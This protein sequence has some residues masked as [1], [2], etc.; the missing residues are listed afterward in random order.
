MRNLIFFVVLTVSITS[1]GQKN[2]KP[3][4]PLPLFTVNNK[5]VSANEFIYLYSQKN[6]GKPEDFTEIK[7]NEYL[8]LFINFK[9]KVAEAQ[10][11]GMDT[12]ASFRK[13]FD[14]YKDELKKPYVAESNELNRLTKETYANLTEEIKASHILITLT[15]NPTPADTIAALQKLT[16]IRTKA[17]GGEDFGKLAQEFSEDPSAKTNNGNLGYFTAMQ[18]VYPFEAAAYKTKVGEISFPVRTRFGYHIIKVFDR[19]PARGEVEVSHILLR[20]GSDN[21]TKV[22]NTI[23]EIYDQLKGGRNWE[24]LCTEYSE[25][26]ATKTNGGKLR[27][28]GVGALASVPEFEKVAFNLQ[29]PGDISDPFQ[30]AIGWHL[31]RLE[32][33]IPVPSYKEIEPSLKRRVSRDE[34]LQI[35]KTALLA[36]RKRELNFAVGEALQKIQS[37]ADTSLIRGRWKY[38]G[39]EAVKNQTLFTIQSNP[40]LAKDFINFVYQNQANSAL[41][42][43]AFMNQLYDRYV[44]ECLSDKEEEILVAQHPEFRS[45]LNEYYEGILLFG[46]MEKEVWNKASEDSTGQHLYYNQN[47]SKYTAGDRLEARIFSTTDKG[48]LEEIQLKISKGDTITKADLKKF[49]SVQ[50]KRLFEKGENKVIDK[51]SWSIEVHQTE[52]EGIYYLV[53]VSRLVPPGPKSF[54]EARAQVISDYQDYLE[55]NWIA[56]LKTKYPVKVNPKGK[57]IVLAELKKKQ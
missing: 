54:S 5:T 34:R 18:M 29:Q 23:F 15:P 51:I 16:E 24:E 1:F 25:D 36:K 12:T 22:K 4:Q 41:S 53:E 38:I 6:H 46:I 3:V 42:P 40:I 35:S 32:K 14:S 33:K 39:D 37:L 9:L 13:E 11:R 21:D 47:K 50:N 52:D 28:F 44:D 2:A 17:M 19:Q 8:D 20:T 45:L 56:N 31:V 27:P 30:S 49:K 7:I 10:E 55:K 57:K 43:E 48:F 26:N